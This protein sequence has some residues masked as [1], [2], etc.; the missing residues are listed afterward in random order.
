MSTLFARTATLFTAQSNASSQI[1]CLTS[2]QKA[3]AFRKKGVL[4]TDTFKSR[5]D[6]LAEIKRLQLRR[7]G[8]LSA[9]K[10]EFVER[11][12]NRIKYYESLSNRLYFATRQGSIVSRGALADPRQAANLAKS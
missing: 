10:T 6:I 12:D 3:I 9:G 5:D 11:V 1:R 4:P 7:Q 2:K 8:L